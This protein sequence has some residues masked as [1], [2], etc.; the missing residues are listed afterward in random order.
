ME[1][2]GEVSK[3]FEMRSDFGQFLWNLANMGLFFLRRTPVPRSAHGAAVYNGKLW[4][5]AG[6]DGNTRLNDMWCIPLSVSSIYQNTEQTPFKKLG[7][8]NSF[9]FVT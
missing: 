8:V 2:C 3:D 5:F 4:V 7:T 9:P 6:Y 1:V